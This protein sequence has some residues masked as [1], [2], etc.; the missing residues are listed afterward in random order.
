MDPSSPDFS[1]LICWTTIN[2]RD[3]HFFFLVVKCH[4]Q[5]RVESFGFRRD[6]RSVLATRRSQQQVG[7]MESLSSCRRPVA[8][9]NLSGTCTWGTADN[10]GFKI[11]IEKSPG[12]VMENGRARF[13]M[14]VLFIAAGDFRLTVLPVS[15]VSTRGVSNW[16]QTQLDELERS[17]AECFDCLYWC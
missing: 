15:R 11:R 3:P 9:W 4:S 8:R 6:V 14:Q 7:Q 13:F 17:V 16:F 2:T 1:R 5:F 12:A 10:C